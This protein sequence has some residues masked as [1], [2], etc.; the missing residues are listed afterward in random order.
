MD[1][2]AI[3]IDLMRALRGRRSQTAFSRRLGFRSNVVY[4]WEAGRAWPSASTALRAAR[5]IGIDLKAGLRDFHRSEPSW[6]ERIDPATPEGVALML[7]ELRGTTPIG[8]LAKRAKRS[9]FAVARWLKGEAEPRLPELLLMIEAC[10]L[11]LLDW[12]CIL[13]EPGK[14]PSVAKDWGELGAAREAA[15]AMPWSHAIMRVLELEDYQALAKHE[16][17]WIACHLGISKEEEQRCLELLVRTR[18]V[19]RQEQ[20]FVVD[21]SRVVDTRMVPERSRD[22][23][24]W[25][26]RVALERIEAGDGLLFSYN[27]FSVS[28]ADLARIREAYRAFYQQMR[29]IIAASEPNQQVVLFTAQMVPLV[30]AKTSSTKQPAGRAK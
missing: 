4:R 17:G 3:A 16:D 10:S 20:R 9:R 15:Y 26:T 13:V 1:Y 30:A 24:D 14:L 23:K 28:N 21:Q 25:W 8:E 6:L 5:R 19:R 29:S 11:R 27:L 18:Q 22:V 12:L 7:S 2:E